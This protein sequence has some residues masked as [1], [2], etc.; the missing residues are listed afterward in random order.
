MKYI[1]IEAINNGDQFEKEFDDLTEARNYADDTW[2]HLT[3][4][5]K[6]ETSVLVLESANP[7]EDA[8]DHYD[9]AIIIDMNKWYA[10]M[11]DAEDFEW[12][13]GSHILSEAKEMCKSGN[14]YSVAVIDEGCD[15]VCVAEYIN[16]IDF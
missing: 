9:G 16:G 10:V 1:V 3:M 5:E 12:G 2:K 15:P 7:D 8:P 13:F 14:Y 11:A 6:A 4:T